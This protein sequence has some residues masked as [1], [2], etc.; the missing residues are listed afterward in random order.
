MKESDILERR[1][2]SVFRIWILAACTA[3][4]GPDLGSAYGVFRIPILTTCTVQVSILGAC[5]A[6]LDPELGSRYGGFRSRT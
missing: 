6:G 2:L 5:A 3:G 1:D 4:S